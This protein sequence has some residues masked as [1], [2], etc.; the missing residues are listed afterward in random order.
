VRGPLQPLQHVPVR[1]PAGEA[2]PHPAPRHHALVEVGRHEVIEGPVQVRG[3]MSTTTRATGSTA[4]SSRA[5]PGRR[6]A[7]DRRAGRW[8]CH[9]GR[10]LLTR[11][12]YQSRTTS[13]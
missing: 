4:A 3:D 1:Q 5:G 11:P 7:P 8:S 12:S 6:A 2:H 13:S 10:S 9:G